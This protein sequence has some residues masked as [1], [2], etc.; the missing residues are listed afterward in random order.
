M[1]RALLAFLVVVGLTAVP[2]MAADEPAGKT[3]ITVSGYGSV[4]LPPDVANVSAAV[5]TNA[6]TA[7]DAVARN[8]TVYDRI[9]GELEKLGIARADVTLAYY[10]V[11]Y[12]PRPHALPP[13]PTGEQYGYTVSRGFNV[14]VRDIA[15]AGRVVDACTSAGATSIN[16]VSFGLADTSGPRATATRKAVEDAR[17][18]ADALAAAA[19]LHVVSIKSIDLG[20][21]MAPPMPVPMMRVA[22]VNAA[23]TQLDQSNV[24]VSVSISV[25][26]VAEP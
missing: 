11:N 22:S 21:A 13:Q 20:G 2:G 16:G 12:N 25:T 6:P 3:A 15:K 18:N 8:N 26:Y 7:A 5:D 14:K 9:V 4:T 19:H 17:A 1:N 23:P 24:S 10:N